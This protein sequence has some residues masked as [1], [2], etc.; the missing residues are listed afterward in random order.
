MTSSR[1]RSGRKESAPGRPGPLNVLDTFPAFESYWRQVRT[2]PLAEQID[3]WEH[4]YLAPWP[5][6]LEK[7]QQSYAAEG[8]D[9]R[10]VARF[11]VF[12]HLPERYERMR[13]LHRTLCRSLPAAWS[14]T[15]R[16]LELD[17][18]V[19][20]VIYVGIGVGAGWA[21]RYEGEPACLFGLENAAEVSPGPGGGFPGAVSHELAHLAHAEWRRR[22]GRRDTLGRSDPYWQLYEEGFAT[23]CERRIE[24][25]RVFR[26][27]TGR[28][29]WLPW[30]FRHRAWLAARFLSNASAGRSVRPFFG[31]WYNIEG[32]IECGYYLGQQVVRE[33]T[34]TTTLRELASWPRALVRRRV[35]STLRRMAGGGR[36]RGPPLGAGERALRRIRTGAARS[37]SSGPA[38]TGVPRRPPPGP[39]QRRSRSGRW[40]RPPA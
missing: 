20:F 4:T 9:W 1:G 27:R 18:P 40:S 31:S 7:Q 29:D 24:R 32:H 14:R 26:L 30:C 19:R 13:Q 16:V 17:F 34:A 21:T 6:L 11:R 23:E 10:R 3:A 36:A 37:R 22:D 8:V 12:P 39:R 2:R 25:P 5:E 28:S 33:W 38:P 35:R 15:A